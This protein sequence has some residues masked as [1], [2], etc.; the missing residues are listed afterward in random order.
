MGRLLDAAG[1]GKILPRGLPNV[2]MDACT[3]MASSR[4]ARV[5]LNT[6]LIT[7]A[8]ATAMTTN[9]TMSRKPP[10]P[11]EAAQDGTKNSG[12]GRLC[13]GVGGCHVDA[14]SSPGGAWPTLPSQRN[15]GPS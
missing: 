9:R 3:S 4:L 7:M 13:G 10:P 5:L 2:S 15:L 12:R 14:P 1:A 6:H 11:E 8:N